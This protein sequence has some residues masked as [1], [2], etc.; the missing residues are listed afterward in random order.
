MKPDELA[1]GEKAREPPGM[2]AQRLVS[3]QSWV[4]WPAQPYLKPAQTI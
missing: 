2:S 3:R 1:K 4:D